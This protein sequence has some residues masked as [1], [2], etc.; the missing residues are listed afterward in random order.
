MIGTLLANRYLID[1]QLGEGGMGVVF[2]AHDT[3]LDRP[4]AIKS[5]S[6]HLLSHDGLKRLLHEAQ[7]AARLTHPNIVAIYDIVDEGEARLI[8]MEYVQ[9][10]TLRSLI[11]LPWQRAVDI[12]VDICRALAFAHGR[13]IVHRDIKPENIIVTPDGTAKLMD[14]GLARS[15]GRS[16]LTQ[17]GLIVGTVVYMGPEQ[18]V[19]GQADARTDLYS[20]GCVMYQMITGRPPFE[21]DDPISV[22]SMHVNVP[23]VAPRFYTPEIPPALESIILRLLAKDPAQRYASAE[24]L[25]TILNSALAPVEAPPEVASAVEAQLAVPT[26]LEMMVRGRLVDREEELGTLKGS[27]ESM[28]SG[29]GQVVLVGG[30]PGIGKTRL[31]QE[32]LVYARLRGCV[33]V[34]GRCFEQEVTIPYLPIAEALRAM[35]R[36]I[37]DDQLQTLVG[38]HAAEVVKLVPDLGLRIR[39]LQPSPPLEPDQERLRLFEHVT[40]FLAAAARIRPVVM[41]LDDLHWADAATLQLLRYIARNVR[42]DRVLLV[43]TYRD[44]ELDRTHPLGNALREMNR[45]RLYTRILLRRLTPAHVGEMIRAIFQTRQPVS[46]EFRDLIYKETEGNPFFVEEVLKHLVEVG[47]LYIVEGRWERKE[48]QEIEV[49][50]SVREVIGRRLERLS[51][52]GVEALTVASVIGRNF[53]F[54]LLRTALASNGDGQSGMDTGQLLDLLEEALESQLIT[55]ERIEEGVR[56]TFAHALVRETLYDGLSLRRKMLFHE[57]VGEALERVYA[58]ALASHAADLAYHFSQVGRTQA[59]K[60]VRYSLQAAGVASGIYAYDEAIMHYRTAVDVLPPDDPRRVEIR[61]KVGRTLLTQGKWAEAIEMLE[62]TFH[63]YEGRGDI[64]SGLRNSLDLAWAYRQIPEPDKAL[65]WAGKAADAARAVG[66]RREL[67]RAFL[68]IAHAL[69]LKGEYGGALTHA[70]EAFET[71]EAVGDQSTA[72]GAR[73]RYLISQPL[74]EPRRPEDLAAV[75]AMA[76]QAGLTGQRVGGRWAL[77]TEAW[78]RGVDVETTLRTNTEAL[79]ISR[80]AGYLFGSAWSLSN[81]AEDLF[82][83]GDWTRADELGAES[84]ATYERIGASFGAH[85]PQIFLAWRRGLRGDLLGGEKA[86]RSLLASLMT[87]RDAQGQRGAFFILADLYLAAGQFETALAVLDEAATAL[88][89]QYDDPTYLFHLG[90]PRAEALSE[91]GRIS[92]ARNFLDRALQLIE[93]GGNWRFAWVGRAIRGKILALSGDWEEATRDFAFAADSLRAAGRP[94]LLGRVL[95]DWGAALVKR[96]TPGSSE[97]GRA[98]LAEALTIFENLGARRDADLTRRLLES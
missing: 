33:A 61:E 78:M 8:V 46:G 67:A 39:D 69:W 83:R 80:R 16:R 43:G 91:V 94:L 24:E 26:L 98:Y 17:T 95:R 96:D 92:E 58:D 44:V 57:R 41:L 55:E 54:D 49:P 73:I 20:L 25:S 65:A 97:Q 68:R 40:A 48:I 30:E 90:V 18:A 29:R 70:R 10:Q 52:E 79:E 53:D 12:A 88:G 3:L 1:V 36:Q 89:L 74:W 22:I 62:R 9:G 87:A 51:P 81:M 76:D 72:V 13:G 21:A 4:V 34:V 50:Q 84:I 5:L 19:S 15:E 11:P 82:E 93:A 75:V 59:E 37:T 6:P 56:Y 77:A 86:L 28:L 71:A 64:A 38:A 66:D 14:F 23:P 45:E 47:A 42:S 60:A 2:K 32:L 85:Y 7:A 31:A 63:D 27:L 35:I